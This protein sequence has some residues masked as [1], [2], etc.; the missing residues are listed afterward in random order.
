MPCINALAQPYPVP[1]RCAVT[2]APAKYM[3]PVTGCAYA[4]LEAFRQLRG[5]T[6]R[7]QRESFGS[8]SAAAAS[9]VDD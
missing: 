7:R 2:A 5:R 1:Q 3:D 6:G 4:S 8:T 9:S